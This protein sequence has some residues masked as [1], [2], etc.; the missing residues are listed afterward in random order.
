MDQVFDEGQIIQPSS[1]SV[2]LYVSAEHI[3][4][5]PVV[6]ITA[7]YA[8]SHLYRAVINVKYILLDFWRSE[9]EKVC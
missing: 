5:L 2:V 6:I 8:A 7:F 1:T 3:G 4:Y 9:H